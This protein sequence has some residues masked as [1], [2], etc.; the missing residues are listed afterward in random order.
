MVLLLLY[1]QYASYDIS[2]TVDVFLYLDETADLTGKVSF[3]TQFSKSN[4]VAQPAKSIRLL[5]YSSGNAGHYMLLLSADDTTPDSQMLRKTCK[6]VRMYN[7]EP[8]S[9]QVVLADGTVHLSCEVS[10]QQLLQVVFSLRSTPP[11][12]VL[13]LL[14]GRTM[15]E[16]TLRAAIEARHGEVNVERSYTVTSISVGVAGIASLFGQLR[17]H[18]QDS[19]MRSC[20]RLAAVDL[21]ERKVVDEELLNRFAPQKAAVI[22]NAILTVPHSLKD[23]IAAE[24]VQ[25]EV[26]AWFLQ[27]AIMVIWQEELSYDTFKKAIGSLSKEFCTKFRS[28]LMWGVM[29][30]WQKRAADHITAGA[31]VVIPPTE[32]SITPP[33]Y[34]PSGQGK[35]QLKTVV[36]RTPE[37]VDEGAV[38]ASPTY[39]PG[40]FKTF[41]ENIVPYTEVINLQSA[42]IYLLACPDACKQGEWLHYGGVAESDYGFGMR[43]VRNTTSHESKVRLILERFKKEHRF[44][45]FGPF[46]FL[47]C[48]MAI[49]CNWILAGSKHPEGM[50]V[51]C[52]ALKTATRPERWITGHLPELLMPGTGLNVKEGDAE[53]AASLVVHDLTYQDDEKRDPDFTPGKSTVLKKLQQK[54]GRPAV[55]KAQKA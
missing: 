36:V 46:E 25:D 28:E 42:C 50:R 49:A 20:A 12:P 8:D 21:I 55:K 33:A 15:I 47:V 1:V 43:W 6:V 17:I 26:K 45:P 3:Q 40:S 48:D 32:G 10:V 24:D 9:V 30:F 54:K 16:T 18:Q 29:F 5:M 41:F 51:Y 23:L 38:V 14:D 4:T 13:L 44:V 31:T 52:V 7:K 27:Y 11:S 19:V 34:V 22:S 39:P 53:A 35:W 37:G 2:V